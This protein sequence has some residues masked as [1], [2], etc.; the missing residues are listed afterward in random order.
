M[1]NKSTNW[2]RGQLLIAFNLY[3]QMPF[4]KMH[5]KN[6]DIVRFAEFI[7]RT[8]SALAMKLT[9]I[10]SLDPAITSSGRR[11]LAGASAAD[12][13]M[14]NE[15]QQDWEHFTL[16]SQAAI[17]TLVADTRLELIEPLATEALLYSEE[18][19]D[20]DYSAESRTSQTQIRIGQQ[21]FRRSVIS[22]YQGRCCITGLTESKL[23]V[24]SH[25]IPW[26]TDKANRLNPRNGLC[27]STL[28]DRAFDQGLFTLTTDFKIRTSQRVK[29]MANNIF[30][31]DWLVR[32]EGLAIELPEKFSPLEE[33][34]DWHSKNIFLNI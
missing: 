7:G 14:W 34:V 13:A 20:Y 10:A 9:N 15:M 29:A 2:S 24:A 28:H 23:L 21:F 6:P 3:C 16:E 30:A 12:R 19:H 4:G 18:E 17:D 31:A 32:L 11:G 1:S 25:I 5:S 33:F 27:L 26:R 22:A 8:P